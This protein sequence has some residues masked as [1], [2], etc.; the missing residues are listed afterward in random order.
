MYRRHILTALAALLGVASLAC[1]VLGV[2]YF[3]QLVAN[4][5]EGVVLTCAD[6]VPRETAL[7]AEEAYTAM[8]APSPVMAWLPADEGAEPKEVTSNPGIPA[9]DAGLAEISNESDASNMSAEP[10][11]AA[12]D[13]GT[14]PEFVSGAV[15]T[16]VDADGFP[17]ST[18]VLAA[19]LGTDIEVADYRL[20]A[21]VAYGALFSAPLGLAVWLWAVCVRGVRKARSRSSYVAQIVLYALPACAALGLTVAFTAT[22]PLFGD[23]FPARWSDFSAWER[24]IQQL[25]ALP[26]LLAEPG[27]LGASLVP[28]WQK[29]LG[30]AA[31]AMVLGALTLSCGG[32]RGHVERRTHG[33]S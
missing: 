21:L 26:R 4:T 17:V 12:A 3:A 33:I 8:G 6:P 11:K 32:A 1:F 13:N 7:I 2:A 25:A 22:F 14:A 29:T 24:S 28:L 15:V 16:R 31:A 5:S 20:L 27:V 30:L 23:F 9:S 18:E 10:S 19:L